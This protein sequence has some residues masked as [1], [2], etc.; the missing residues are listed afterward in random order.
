M[1]E[2]SA[3]ELCRGDRKTH[4]QGHRYEIIGHKNHELGKQLLQERQG[5][6]L[7]HAL[8]LLHEKFPR[9]G[10][11]RRGQDEHGTEPAEHE[12]LQTKRLV[13]KKE[14]ANAEE[15]EM[16]AIKHRLDLCHILC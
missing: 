12:V 16:H 4:K 6:P 1:P 5:R 13:H 15:D 9:Q 8:G 10:D 11:V 14:Y 7:H 3:A 2:I